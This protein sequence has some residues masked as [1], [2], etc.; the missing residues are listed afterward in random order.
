MGRNLRL[1]L[2]EKR[3][4]AFVDAYIKDKGRSPSYREIAS[5]LGVSYQR[6]E[7]IVRAL[8]KKGVLYYETGHR[9]GLEILI[10]L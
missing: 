4:L 9:R 5:F 10:K 3:T 8:K 1:S 6:V 7:Q 2:M